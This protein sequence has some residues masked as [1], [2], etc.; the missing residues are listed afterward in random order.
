VD[1]VAGLKEGHMDPTWSQPFGRAQT[2]KPFLVVI[3]VAIK[4]KQDVQGGGLAI[5]VESRELDPDSC[6][7]RPNR[8]ANDIDLA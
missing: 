4:V 6:C 2:R 3:V 1:G 8:A 7:K 5:L